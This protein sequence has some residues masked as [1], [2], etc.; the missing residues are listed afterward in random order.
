MNDP[1]YVSALRWHGTKQEDGR[2]EGIRLTIGK[3]Q[4]GIDAI[5]IELSYEEWGKV[6]AGLTGKGT[7]R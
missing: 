1:T 3:N 6:L 4:Y 2:T 5:E 7:G